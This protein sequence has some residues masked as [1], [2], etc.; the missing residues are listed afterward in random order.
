MIVELSFIGL[1]AKFEQ[2]ENAKY[3]LQYFNCSDQMVI[4]KDVSFYDKRL[5]SDISKF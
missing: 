3:A 2:E 1:F 4:K 5:I